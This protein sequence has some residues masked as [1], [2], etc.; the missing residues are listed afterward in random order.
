VYSFIDI[1]LQCAQMEYTLMGDYYG[2]LKVELCTAEFAH[3]LAAV[4][5]RERMQT[6]APPQVR[7]KPLKL[8][9]RDA[10]TGVRSLRALR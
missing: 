6:P 9:R 1:V 2:F 8:S 3:R 4:S 7:R 10:G 5:L